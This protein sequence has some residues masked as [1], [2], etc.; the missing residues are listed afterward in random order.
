MRR[1]G[2]R[3]PGHAGDPGP[4]GQHPGNLVGEDRIVRSRDELV[5]PERDVA[6]RELL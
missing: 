6:F 2:R 3:P 1:P 4:A 5:L